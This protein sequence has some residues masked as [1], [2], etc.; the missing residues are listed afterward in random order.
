MSLIDAAGNLQIVTGLAALVL[1][2]WTP[3]N[4]TGGFTAILAQ[5]TG[6]ESVL[7]Q[8][9]QNASITAGAV[10]WQGT[11]DGINWVSIPAGQILDPTSMTFALIANP[12]TFVISTNK[13]FLILMGGFQSIRAL[14]S[15][16][17]TGAGASIAPFVVQLAYSPIRYQGIAT[18][19][20][21]GTN[22]IGHVITD[23]AAA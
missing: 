16:P 4:W 12:Y 8:L 20:P 23:P 1:T 21:A 18:A 9:N 15:T 14:E 17:M 10:T 19:L 13:S 6:C 2:P 22:V 3:V 7:V 5:G 11:Y